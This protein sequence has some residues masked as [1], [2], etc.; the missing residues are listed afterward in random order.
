MASRRSTSSRFVRAAFAAAIC[1]SFAAPAYAQHQH[2]ARL[3]ADLADHLV[4]NSSSVELILDG[5]RATIDRLAARY[6]LVVKKYLH[7]GGVLRVNAGQLSALQSDTEI[8]HL[9]GDIK[10]KSAAVDPVDEGIG[11]DQ[12]WAGAGNLPKL[13]GKGVAVAV[14]DSGID[15][16]HNALKGRVLY[17]ADF[18]GGNGVDRFGHGTHVAAIIAGQSGQLAD[19]RVYRGVAPGAY[20]L[21]LRVLNDNGEGTAS[22]VIE[23]IDWAIDHQRAY[24]IR[25]I[26]LSLGAPVLQPYR[27]DPVCA[28]V[29]RAV[30]AGIL[31]VTAAGNHGQTAQGKTVLG[32]ITSP[33]NSPYAMTVGALDTNGTAERSDD[34]VAT[35]SSHG[36]TLFDLVV[37]PDIVAP[38]RRIT[39]AEAAGSVLSVSFPQ[40]HVAG[41]GPN[42]Y[43]KGSGTSMAAAFVS[44]AAALL[45]EERPSLQPLGVKAALQ[46]SSSFMPEAGL[47]RAGTGSLNV[48]AAAEFVRDRDLGDTTIAG[49]LAQA[50]HLALAPS[51]QLAILKEAAAASPSLFAAQRAGKDLQPQLRLKQGPAKV[52][53]SRSVLGSADA[54][55]WG[56]SHA[57]VWGAS[58]A[59]VWGASD[60]LVWGAS[61]ALVWG[62]SDALV[63]GASDALVWGASDALVWGA[64]DALVWGASDALVW[65]AS[66]ALVW[67]ASDALV[68]GAS[69]ALVWGASDALVWGASDALVWGA[70][71]AL[72][73]G[74]S[75]ALVWGASDALVWGASDALV[76]GASDALVW[77]A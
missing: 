60:A 34:A 45:L 3:S 19:T 59:L 47:V 32:G 6:N 53:G 4:A 13:S 28:A 26:N 56:A 62:A 17:T 40:Q 72:V 9:S 33:G 73:W 61:D 46:L 23:A 66:D 51:D 2:R 55:V 54:L 42:A 74:A 63:W 48:L 44:G 49:E 71:D 14:I 64:S 38:G 16:K 11:A 68:W 76:W 52:G 22:N 70:S 36:P 77:G 41:N 10:Y 29:E 15:P 25:V 58:D 27:D 65:G 8:D 21:N 18:T 57:L 7:S 69:N 67:G 24:N 37:K 35:F 1:A 20:L 30:R 75:D 39:S 31:V 5:D 50:S 43:I 12:V